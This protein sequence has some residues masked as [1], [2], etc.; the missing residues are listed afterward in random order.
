M[1]NPTTTKPPGVCVTWD[2]AKADWSEIKG[3]EKIVQKIW[4]EN[5]AEAYL[6]LWQC[7]LSF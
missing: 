6:F 2:E 3:D 1:T 7:V 5:D 4:E